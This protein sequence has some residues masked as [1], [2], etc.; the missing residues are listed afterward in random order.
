MLRVIDTRFSDA[1]LL[2]PDVFGDERGFFKETYSRDK[3]VRAGVTDTFVQDNVS[4][5]G[6]N[7]LRGMHYDMRVA[8][9]VQCLA[10]A[11]F[12]VIV[13]AREDSPTYLQWEGYELTQDN[14][15]Q[16]YV[17]RGFAHGFLTLSDGVIASYKQTEHFDPKHERGLAWDDPAI[18]IA[19][20]LGDPP[21]ISTKDQAW[22]HVVRA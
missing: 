20:P 10:G 14:H 22:P 16:I 2:E 18:G 6:R 21:I 1:K 12:D 11:I 8:K 7:V 4:R 5:S 15:R 17:P 13:D 19:W 3:Y 9:L